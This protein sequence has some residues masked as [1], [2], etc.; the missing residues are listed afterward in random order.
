MATKRVIDLTETSTLPTGSYVMVDSSTGGTKK[1]DLS[2][3]SGAIGGAFDVLDAE[4]V[5]ALFDD[6]EDET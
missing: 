1:Y 3:I 4:D 5:A 2:A 6:E